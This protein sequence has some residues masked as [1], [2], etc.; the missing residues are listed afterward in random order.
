MEGEQGDHII[1]F[2]PLPLLFLYAWNNYQKFIKSFLIQ[3]MWVQL[4]NLILYVSILI[5]FTWF[6]QTPNWV[7]FT[8]CRKETKH[9]NN[10]PIPNYTASEWVCRL[11]SPWF[12]SSQ[13]FSVIFFISLNICFLVWT[14][15]FTASIK[16][17]GDLKVRQWGF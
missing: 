8:L 5:F 11:M 1:Y 2:R 4:K 9:K 13:F 17:T 3:Y 7:F 14:L 12:Q 16:K 10:K 6:L 15:N